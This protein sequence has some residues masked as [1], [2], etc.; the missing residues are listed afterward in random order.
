MKERIGSN[1]AYLA[2]VRDKKKNPQHSVH[3][4]QPTQEE[5][6]TTQHSVHGLQPHGEEQASKPVLSNLPPHVEETTPKQ[7]GS[8]RVSGDMV[9]PVV[10]A[11]FEDKNVKDSAD[12]YPVE[13]PDMRADE[14]KPAVKPVK[15]FDPSK[16]YMRGQREGK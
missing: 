10:D 2:Q 8:P 14:A 12:T 9:E 7:S 16:V 3:G 4:L 15:G 13:F 11:S 1:G 5:K 6:Q